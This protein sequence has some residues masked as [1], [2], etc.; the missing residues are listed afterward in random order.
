MSSTVR[1]IVA[2]A[3]IAAVTVIGPKP[4]EA[5]CLVNCAYYG[6][7]YGGYYGGYSPAA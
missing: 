2:V 1:V 4:A 7:N 5:R 6:E 3:I